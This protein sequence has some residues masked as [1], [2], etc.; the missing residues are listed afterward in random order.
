MIFRNFRMY[1]HRGIYKKVKNLL[2][3]KNPICKRMKFITF[4]KYSSFFCLSFAEC[5]KLKY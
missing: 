2:E 1:A 3:K 5:L 4:V